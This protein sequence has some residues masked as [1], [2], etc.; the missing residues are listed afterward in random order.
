MF[1]VYKREMRAYIHNFYGWLFAAV[2]LMTAGI[3]VFVFNFL[4][5][6]ADM[7]YAMPE[8][9][10][11]VAVMAPVLCMFSLPA[12]RRSGM[13]DMYRSLPIKTGTVILAKYLAMLT[14][15][16]VPTLVLCL[17][18]LL[19]SLYSAAAVFGAYAALLVFFLLGAAALA[20]CLFLS[21]FTKHR[22]VA[23]GLGWGAMFL[24]LGLPHL[25]DLLPA[26]VGW[27]A[28]LLRFVSPFHYY[29][30]IISWQL[31]DLRAVAWL[32]GC[33]LFFLLL[34]VVKS[35]AGHVR[36]AVMVRGVALTAAVACLSAALFAAIPFLP[37][38]TAEISA[39]GLSEVSAETSVFLQNMTRDVTVWW[40]CED[41]EPVPV[42]ELLLDKY[43][44]GAGR[45]TV[46][47]L[48]VTDTEDAEVARLTKAYGQMEGGSFVVECAETGRG[49]AIPFDDL[50]YY[51]NNYLDGIF[52]DY[53]EAD[54][55]TSLKLSEAELEYY[56][57]LMADQGIDL[58]SGSSTLQHFRGEAMLTGALDYVTTDKMPVVYQLNGH[59]G[60]LA[61]SIIDVLD[62]KPLDLSEKNTMPLDAS[63][64]VICDPTSDLTDTEATLLS[65]FLEAGGSLVLS[66]A[67]GCES[68]KNLMALCATFGV[69]AQPGR[70]SDP[71]SLDEA[72]AQKEP[73]GTIVPS[74]NAQ[75]QIGGMVQNAMPQAELFMTN[76]HTIAMRPEEELE[77]L[78]VGVEKLLVTTDK[79]ELVIS[80][81]ETRPVPEGENG[82]IVA[83]AASR[84]I[85]SEEDDGTVA[86][87][88]WFADDG[89]FTDAMIE[90]TAKSN[91]LYLAAT[92]N[93]TTASFS[94]PYNE[95]EAVCLSMAVTTYMNTASMIIWGVVLVAIIPLTTLAVGT[96]IFRKR[97]RG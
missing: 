19:L 55:M 1:A 9:A 2:L 4:A 49:R 47:V 84:A 32:I 30:R 18:P 41:G 80:G 5:G 29:D 68:F 15:L 6:A 66:T 20:I 69:N 35:K 62:I 16:A 96:V 50:Y 78:L 56:T 31:F 74:F 94:S 40:L 8:L 97:Y 51:T 34:T 46:R 44:G 65:G 11:A 91:L 59:G 54:G 3:T 37:R 75:S 53:L 88:T 21:S 17:Y 26:S 63:C 89:L 27:P 38:S 87:L 64:V 95:L 61:T 43:E 28:D 90:K 12:D 57:K 14:V 42:L 76:A 10:Y 58:G 70:V 92:I 13:D 72:T 48:D 33:A 85:V 71:D 73:V 93:A 39:L 81:N 79:A 82:F 45:V 24:L 67:P 86:Y 77:E 23:A 52:K 60:G 83:V 22:W 36:P 25:A 7:L